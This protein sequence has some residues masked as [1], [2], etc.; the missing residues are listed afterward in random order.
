MSRWFRHYA[1][2]MRDEKLVGVAL[3]AKQPV[4]RVIWIWGAILESA[5][6]INDAGRYELDIAE[7]S[8]F[9]RSDESDIVSITA[10]LEGAGRVRENRVVNWANRQFQSDRSAARQKD[11]RK[12]QKAQRDGGG[13]GRK[14]GGDGRKT[15]SDSDI[16]SPSRHG[17]APELETDTEAET[18]KK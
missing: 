16:T 5:A 12:R 10:C 7:I 2:M 14:V 3:R 13:D 6:E 9:L 8:Y 15:E 17:D 4:E 11:Y 18:E 1:G